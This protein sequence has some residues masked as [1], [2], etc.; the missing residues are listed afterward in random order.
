MKSGI[1]KVLGLI[2]FL[3]LFA[4]TGQAVLSS[5]AAAPSGTCGD[6][7]T[8]TLSDE[9]T[10]TISGKGQMYNYE[11]NALNDKRPWHD[12]DVKDNIKSVVIDNGVESIG[13]CAF[14]GCTKISSVSIPESVTSIGTDAFN[15]CQNLTSVTI[16]EGVENIGSQAFY[17][18]RGLTSVTIPEGVTSISENMFFLCIALKNVTIPESVTSI[19]SGAFGKCTSLGSVIIPESVENIGKDAFKSCSSLTKVTILSGSTKIDDTAFA[20][21]DNL[22]DVYFAGTED[23][24]DSVK[25]AFPDITSVHYIEKELTI[26]VLDQTYPY[27]GYPH[28]EAEPVYDKPEDIAGKVTVEGLEKG[29]SLTMIVLFGQATNVGVYKIEIT[30]FNTLKGKDIYIPKLNPGTLTIGYE[31]VAMPGANMTHV[32]GSGNIEQ[33]AAK[34]IKPVVFTADDGYYFP[35]DYKVDAVNGISVTRNSETQIT[36]AGTPTGKAMIELPAASKKDQPAHVHDLSAVDAK[37][38]TCEEAGNK[39]YYTCSTC[40]K[41]FEDKTALVEITDKASVTIKALGHK[42]D[43]GKITVRPTYA[44]EGERTYTCERDSSHTKIEKIPKKT[45]SSSDKDETTGTRQPP[46]FE[47]LI[48]EY[49]GEYWI[50]YDGDKLVK[51]NWCYVFFNGISYWYHFGADGKMQTGWVQTNE[52]TYYLWPISDGWKGRM[53]TGCLKIG[54]HSYYFEPEAGKN[55]GRMYRNEQTPYGWADENGIILEKEEE[56]KEGTGGD[57]PGN[58]ETDVVIRGGTSN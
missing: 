2:V 6:D 48:D 47:S 53:V 17:G 43:A 5:Y 4:F 49:G 14:S 1:K 31:V 55:Q 23:Q 11:V 3:C 7:L 25:G 20:G 38:A 44:S 30:G 12:D 24:W 36:V 40:G 41:W 46:R 34:D 22:K 52:G 45:K 58:D 32:K 26:T 50:C 13:N 37:E 16:P 33:I 18:C 39:T 15:N 19:G 21:D 8:W 29:D 51:D 9:G 57:S 35:E 42:W 27:D 10:L 28:G 54:E 56:K